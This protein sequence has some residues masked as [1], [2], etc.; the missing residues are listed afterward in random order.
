MLVGARHE[1]WVKARFALT[2]RAGV[3]V[4]STSK[5]QIVFLIG[6]S[7]REGMTLAAAAVV[8]MVLVFSF[9]SR[10]YPCM[11]VVLDVGVLCRNLELVRVL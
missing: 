6:R 10:M 9:C 5:R 3:R 4:P 2:R 11:Y 1:G 8:A 7:V